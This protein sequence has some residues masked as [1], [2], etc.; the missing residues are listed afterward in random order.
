[1][2][3]AAEPFHDG[4]GDTRLADPGLARDQHHPTL[5]ALCLLPSSQEQVNLFVAAD[6][7]RSSGA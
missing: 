5:A 2:W 7:R 6:Q 3:L 1:V 4:L